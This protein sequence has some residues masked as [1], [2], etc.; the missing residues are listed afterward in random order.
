[1]A[2]TIFDDTGA[3]SQWLCPACRGKHRSHT[4]VPGQCRKARPEGVPAAIAPAG[5]SAARGSAD[6]PGPI[7]PKSLKADE[8]TGQYVDQV[9]REYAEVAKEA[10]QQDIQ[11]ELA[12]VLRSLNN[13]LSGVAEMKDKE[14]DELLVEKLARSKHKRE[15]IAAMRAETEAICGAVRQGEEEEKMN[16]LSEQRRK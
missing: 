7:A 5:P 12:E 14:L 15:T 9:K 2:R 10:A 16:T 8:G 4:V 13:K 3:L 1:M 6:P 11:K